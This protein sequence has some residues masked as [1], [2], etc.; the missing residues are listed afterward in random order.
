MAI[1]DAYAR[2]T[3]YE[4]LLPDPEFADRHFPAVAE[5]AGERGVDPANPAAFVML[6]AAQAALAELRDD[7]ASPESAND[8]GI[9]LYFAYCMWLAGPAVALVRADTLRRLLSTQHGTPPRHPSRTD[10]PTRHDAWTG[11]LHERAGYLQL[12]QHLVWLE[13]GDDGSPGDPPARDQPPH[14]AACGSPAPRPRHLHR[15]RQPPGPHVPPPATSPTPESVDGLFWA[16]DPGGILHLAL[17]TGV[18]GDRP[19]YGIV[20]VPPQPV[21]TLSEWAAGP[22]REGGGDFTTAL[23][24]ADLDGLLGLRTPAEVFKLAALAL[25]FMARER[26]TLDPPRPDRANTSDDPTAPTHPAASPPPT[27]LPSALL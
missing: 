8:H 1:H 9:V 11:S 12:P 14:P 15:A 22:A 10:S 4:L 3:P 21:E 6:G 7:D 24:G 26:P 27:N 13:E 2:L 16:V 17:V 5:E 19:G 25:G 18:R 23:P 20:P